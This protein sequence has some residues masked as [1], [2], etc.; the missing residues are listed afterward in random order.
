[1]DARRRSIPIKSFTIM[2]QDVD[3]AIID[4]SDTGFVKIHVKEGT[5]EILG[6][7][8]VG[9]RA[10]ELINELS[11]IMSAGIGMH[12]L[13]DVLHT[14]PSQSDAIRLAAIAFRD[15]MPVTP[16]AR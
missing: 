5:G 15:D 1:V 4:G 13:A 2:M 3:R 11:V 12:R 16:R 8:I 9:S 6:A 14:Y 10:G 7:T